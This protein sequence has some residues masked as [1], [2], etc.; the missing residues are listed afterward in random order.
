MTL[1]HLQINTQFSTPAV[2]ADSPYMAMVRIRNLACD[3]CS[4]FLETF[5]VVTRASH[6]MG[7]GLEKMAPGW[8]L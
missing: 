7:H 8:R 4:Y 2:D 6:R 3:I 5:R 1:N